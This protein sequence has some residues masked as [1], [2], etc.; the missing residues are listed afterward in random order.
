MQTSLGG[1]DLTKRDHLEN[2]D[3]KGRILKLILK[4]MMGGSGLHS[5]GLG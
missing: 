3:T 4:N 2:S 1:G 5:S